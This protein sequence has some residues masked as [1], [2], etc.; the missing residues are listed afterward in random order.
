MMDEIELRLLAVLIEKSLTQQASYP[1]T[2]NALLLGANQKQN[3]EPVLTLTEGEVAAAV[4][5]L[6]NKRSVAPATPQAGARANRF[7]HTVV[8]R[9]GWDRHDQALLAELMLRGPQTAGELRGRAGRMAT[10]ADS[11]AVIALLGRLSEHDPP[12]VEELPREP[13]RSANRFRH[14]LATE[15]SI[16]DDAALGSVASAAEPL[17]DDRVSAIED[18]VARLARRVAALEEQ[19][20]MSNDQDAGRDV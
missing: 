9:F 16:G 7:A 20:G 1:L 6:Q 5:R 11:V 19:A 18:V 2:L 10:F 15:A 12:F 3:R 4:R 8:E 14:L 17:T 13:G